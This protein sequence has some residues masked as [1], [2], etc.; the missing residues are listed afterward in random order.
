MK[1]ATRVTVAAAAFSFVASLVVVALS[2]L[3]HARSYRP[4]GLLVAYLLLTTLFEAAQVRTLFLTQI[5][6][7]AYLREDTEHTRRCFARICSRDTDFKRCHQL[8][9]HNANAE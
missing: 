8:C 4:S 1:F 3:E 7:F 2:T 5:I 9:K 6:Q